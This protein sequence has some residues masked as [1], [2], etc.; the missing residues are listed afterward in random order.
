MDRQAA[1][2]YYAVLLNRIA[3]IR[4]RQSVLEF[5]LYVLAFGLAGYFALNGAA[6][7]VLGGLIGFGFQAVFN[8][9][10]DLKIE[11]IYIEYLRH[12]HEHTDEAEHGKRRSEIQMAVDSEVKKW[13]EF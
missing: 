2:E 9:I 4:A 8:R 11:L 13:W 1:I 10:S 3:K 12:L 7:A 6:G 5:V